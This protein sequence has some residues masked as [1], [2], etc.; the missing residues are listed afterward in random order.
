MKNSHN[1]TSVRLGELRAPVEAKAKAE[2]ITLT[3]ALKQSVRAYLNLP[4]PQ[5]QV[6]TPGEND[7]G[8]TR[9]TVRFEGLYWL[10]I[11]RAA[12]DRIS[13][14]ALIRKAVRFYLLDGRVPEIKGFFGELR[15]AHANM[16]RVGGNLNR[17]ARL[18][19]TDDIFA[20]TE[21]ALAHDDL[22]N[23]FK[24]LAD[25]YSRVERKLDRQIP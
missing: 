2:G 3:E 12:E 21:L 8:D 16:A 18:L 11:E 24:L 10:L 20:E 23:M 5:V 1:S 7:E 14:S 17:I 19:N 15:T 22:L 13:C 9:L 25:L 6:V 4:A